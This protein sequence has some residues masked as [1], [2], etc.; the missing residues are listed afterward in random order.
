MEA[1]LDVEDVEDDAGRVTNVDTGAVA[2]EGG[3]G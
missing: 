1:G 2:E 3:R